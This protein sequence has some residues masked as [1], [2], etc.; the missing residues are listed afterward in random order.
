M[1]N[2]NEIS[3]EDL[4]AE[5]HQRFG[6]SWCSFSSGVRSRGECPSCKEDT[7]LTRHHLVPIAKGAGRN[8]EVNQRYVKICQPCHLLTHA[9]WGPGNSYDGPQD[10]ELFLKELRQVYLQSVQD[11]ESD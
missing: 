1:V 4:L 2:W 7:K 3:D 11:K 8:L 6:E 9:Q 10:R 5:L